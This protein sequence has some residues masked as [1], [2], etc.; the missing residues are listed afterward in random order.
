MR[1]KFGYSPFF[2]ILIT[3]LITACQSLPDFNIFGSDQEADENRPIS[4]FVDARQ[5]I[6][7]GVNEPLAIASY[8]RGHTKLSALEISINGQP[9]RTEATAG[10]PN[11]F[12]EYLATAQ[13]LV[14]GQPSQAS[15]QQVTFPS[16]A[17]QYLLTAGGPVQT[18]N[19]PL[20]PPSSVWTV[21]HIWTGYTPGTYDLSLVAVDDAQLRSEPIHQRIEVR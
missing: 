18:S 19:F 16:P 13:A 6:R 1:K 9:L 17:C 15:L 8:H 2:V 3:L 5:S 4:N 21:C 12:P 7:V 14:W 20:T 10:Q 11:T